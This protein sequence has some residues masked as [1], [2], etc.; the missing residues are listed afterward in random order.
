MNHPVVV[1]ARRVLHR[2]AYHAYNVAHAILHPRSPHWP[3]VR[4]AWL[5]THPHCANPR[6]L[7]V[8]KIE[9]HHRQ[10]YHLYPNLELNPTNF[11]TLCMS[12]NEC[13]LRVGHGGSWRAYNPDIDGT[14]KKL[15]A[16][17][18]AI[19]QDAVLAAVRADRKT[20]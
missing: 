5:K 8:E 7:S 3:A 9:V 11:V 6:C 20:A 15:D 13:H 4:R 16:A 14:L 12:A 2:V 18:T 17:N 10:P 19:A 1:A